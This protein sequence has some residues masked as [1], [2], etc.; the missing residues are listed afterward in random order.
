MYSIHAMS[1]TFSFPHNFLVTFLSYCCLRCLIN[2]HYCPIY[3]FWWLLKS[4]HL[5]LWANLV[6]PKVY[7]SLPYSRLLNGLWIV[8]ILDNIM[9]VNIC[10]V[11]QT[12]IWLH[13]IYSSREIF[14]T[15]QV[16]KY[17]VANVNSTMGFNFYCALP[18]IILL[19]IFCDIG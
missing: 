11:W 3:Q 13:P 12:I 5:S 9:I 4:I 10:H 16:S 1:C 17:V 18:S 15:L 14:H 6:S 7:T 19:C 8:V 2:L